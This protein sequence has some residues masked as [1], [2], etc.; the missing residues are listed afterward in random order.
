[1]SFARYRK[2]SPSEL[3][4]DAH[5]AMTRQQ[6]LLAQGQAVKSNKDDI[7]STQVTDTNFALFESPTTQPNP[8]FTIDDDSSDDS[9]RVQGEYAIAKEHEPDKIYRRRHSRCLVMCIVE[10]WKREKIRFASSGRSNVVP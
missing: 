5:R 4:R 1:M 10:L 9:E 3:S 7:S 6:Q 2:K 8:P